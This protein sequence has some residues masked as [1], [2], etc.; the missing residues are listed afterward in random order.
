M[1]IN[2]TRPPGVTITELTQN[3]VTPQLATP[4]VLCLVGPAS[5]GIQ[6]TNEAVTLSEITGINVA[7]TA[8]NPTITLSTTTGL[9]NNTKYLISS[10]TIPVASKIT[11]TYNSTTGTTQ[12]LSTGTGV[13]SSDSSPVAATIAPFVAL[14]VKSADTVNGLTLVSDSDPAKITATQPT[15]SSTT[16]YPSNSYV[17]DNSGNTHAIARISSSTGT[18]NANIASTNVSNITINVTGFTDTKLFGTSGTLI[19]DSEQISYSGAAYNSNQI[20]VTV[21]ARGVNGTTAAAHTSGA[22]VTSNITVPLT[23]T[24]GNVNSRTV[25]VS[26]S[27]TPSDYYYPYKIT[28]AA[29][30]SIESRFGPAFA[31]D[32]VTIKSPLTLAAKIAIE[33]G[34][35]NFILQPLFNSTDNIDG[36]MPTRTAPSNA[37]IVAGT[38]TWSKA[39]RAV[40]NEENIGVIVPIVGQSSAYSYGTGTTVE[41]NDAAQLSI[42]QSLLTHIGYMDSAYDQLIV[43]IVGSDSTD[44]TLAYA[45]IDNQTSNANS[46]RQLRFSGKDYS[47]RL[48]YIDQTDF[49]RNSQTNSLTKIHL[50][51]QYAAAAI[52]GMLVSGA[53]SN[54]LTRRYV[55]GFTSVNDSRTKNQ[56]T[57]DSGNGLFVIENDK[58][59]NLQIRHAITINNT[60]TDKAELSVIRAK[61]FMVNSLRQTVDNQIIGRVVADDSALITVR[62]IVAGALRLLQQ[63]GDIVSFS[64]VETQMDS[65][66]PTQIGVR[67]SYRPAF[68]VN[69]INISF[70]VDL[71]NG[72]SSLS[73]TDQANIG[74]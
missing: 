44:S 26:Y 71:T 30:S 58:S 61:H 35:S 9:V 52:G 67:F 69:Y 5:G 50:G 59:G 31:D 22:T 16:G 34:A 24:S 1:A 12:T 54:S 14:N 15:Y 43:G 53:V 73:T 23:S 48:V 65:I 28:G 62:Q 37:A 10:S 33:N 74:A 72:I 45:P 7:T 55:S 39:F 6:V 56:K 8:T 27:Y 49:V 47:E 70:S 25:Y 38:T 21:V 4:D 63:D 19:I 42:F 51:G 68:P 60:S 3:N 32:G 13:T 17:V 66:D 29:Y 64:G 20:T 2:Y 57:I 41:L 40:Q 18:L 46:L 11:F 36:P